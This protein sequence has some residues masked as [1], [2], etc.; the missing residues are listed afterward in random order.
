MNKRI[1]AF[2]LAGLL[3]LTFLVNLVSAYGYGYIDLRYGSEQVIRWV[4]DFGAPIF[5]ALLGGQYGGVNDGFLFERF[6]LFILLLSIVYISI[7]NVPVFA[8]NKPV[9]SIISFVI[10]LI[11]IRFMDFAWLM[12]ILVQYAVLGIAITAILP[13]I[14]YLLFLHGMS[15]SATVRK[16]GWILFIVVYFGMWATTDVEFYGEI[17]MWTMLLA[18]IFLFLDGTIHSYY[19]MQQMKAGGSRDKWDHILKLQHQLRDWQYQ[20]QGMPQNVINRRTKELQ[21]EIK[22][23][24]KMTSV[25]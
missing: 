9:I 7:K 18:V 14:I 23:F 5:S 12:T 11:A 8:D 25:S 3:I 6:L 17:Y 19:L 16:I 15:N 1:G 13:F 2:L 10:P 21:D 4:E 24:Q 20:S 22:R